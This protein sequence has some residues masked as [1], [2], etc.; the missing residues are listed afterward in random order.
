M[1]KKIGIIG[2]GSIGSRYL[3]VLSNSFKNIE[4]LV[5][6]SDP[7]KPNPDLNYQIKILYSIEEAISLGMQAAIIATPSIF[8]VDQLKKLIVNNIHVLV[9]KPLSN[10]L[11]SL[12]NIENINSKIVKLMGYCFRYD[13]AAIF[14]KNLIKKLESKK[15]IHARI[16]S[17]SYLP[18]W[19]PKQDYR[20]SCSAKKNLGGGVLLELSHELDFIN[21]FFEDIDSVYGSYYNSNSLE[22]DVEDSADLIFESNN[23]YNISVHL[24]F[25]TF[26]RR[27]K[28]TIFFDKEKLVWDILKK[29]VI[30]YFYDGKIKEYL[31]PY[32]RNQ[33]FID[34]L[35]HFLDCINSKK[36]P[37]CKFDDGI[38]VLRMIKAIKL[39]K[40]NNKKVS[41]K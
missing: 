3:R 41:L 18:N 17:G 35:T 20:S 25:N 4:I 14:F 33:L 34:Q 16:E 6:R 27:R 22:I 37:I 19:R 39:S 15:I 24:D 36:S 29:K 31:F 26:D 5:V 8:H 38:K 13:P 12:N 21:W 30:R 9:E 2:L 10:T 28:C 23:G 7:N 1:I 40:K 11:N 32:E